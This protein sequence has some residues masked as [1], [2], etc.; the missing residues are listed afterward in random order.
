MSSISGFIRRAGNHTHLSAERISTDSIQV[1]N[2][3][4][5][6]GSGPSQVQV[7]GNTA[8]I[9]VNANDIQ[10]NTDN[11]TALNTS[12]SGTVIPAVNAA[13]TNIVSLQGS[14][15]NHTTRIS[16]LETS[17]GQLQVQLNSTTTNLG[18]N[19]TAINENTAEITQHDNLLDLHT[20]QIANL[21]TS[22]N[23][24]VDNLNTLVAAINALQARTTT[25]EGFH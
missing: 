24:I 6:P 19:Q 15:L 9:T 17:A 8:A 7:D 11:I 14:S 16:Q 10:T 21:T 25:L 5:T 2:P 18:V 12:L 4:S 22:V 23:E 20:T 3:G 1:N 13:Q